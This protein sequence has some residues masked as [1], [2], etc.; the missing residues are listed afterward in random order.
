MASLSLGLGLSGADL[1]AVTP[2]ATVI[3]SGRFGVMWHGAGQATV[4]GGTR[5]TTKEAVFLDKG[6]R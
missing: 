3:D 1:S 2:R 4:K 5:I 6:G